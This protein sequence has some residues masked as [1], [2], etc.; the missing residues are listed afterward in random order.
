MSTNRTLD[1]SE[2]AFYDTQSKSIEHLCGEV[3]ASHNNHCLKRLQH[4]IKLSVAPLLSRSLSKAS[5]LNHDVIIVTFQ[6]LHR[7]IA[8]YYQYIVLYG[9]SSNVVW[10]K[11]L[12]LSFAPIT[13]RN[14][15]T[16]TML[17]QFSWQETG[18]STNT[19]YGPPA[20]MRTSL[21]VKVWFVLE[22][23]VSTKI[24]TLSERLRNDH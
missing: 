3:S 4:S 10:S 11:V 17:W 18:E 23:R 21:N 1:C 22:F 7:V 16:R 8:I 24:H 6:F 12:R 13:A 19:L 15:K 14:K 9:K 20:P 2:V 5:T